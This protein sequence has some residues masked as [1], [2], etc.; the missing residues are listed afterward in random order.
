[1]GKKAE[2]EQREWRLR[3][4]QELKSGEQLIEIEDGLFHGCDY[5][6]AMSIVESGYLVDMGKV[7]ALG[8]GIYLAKYLSYS[9]QPSYAK[10]VSGT[11]HQFVFVNRLLKGRVYA[12]TNYMKRP[13]LKGS[14]AAS[15]LK[16]LRDSDR[17]DTAVSP[18][19]NNPETFCAPS[20]DMVLPEFL[21]ELSP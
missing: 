16:N 5:E 6:A 3:N 9:L 10:P 12:G 15:G 14:F 17:F 2:V 19:I 18:N 1:M 11:G 13:V 8:I 7:G 4:E 20:A 21:L